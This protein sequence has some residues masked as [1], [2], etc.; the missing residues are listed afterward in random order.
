MQDRLITFRRYGVIERFIC[1]DSSI[2]TGILFFTLILFSAC[3]AAPLVKQACE[4]KDW[5]IGIEKGADPLQVNW[6]NNED[7]P[8][9]GPKEVTDRNARFTADPFLLPWKNTWYLFFEVMNRGT[10]QGDIGYAISSDLVHWQYQK[11]I[12]DEPFHLSYPYV[13]RSHGSFYMIPESRQAKGIRLY[14]AKSFPEKWEFIKELIPGNFSDSSIIYFNNYW[15]LFTCDVPYSLNIFYSK[16]IFG[17]W[18]PH[19]L[20]PITKDDKTKS[21]PGGRMILDK[22]HPIRFAQDGT[23]GYGHSIRA[24]IIDR[25]TSTQYLEHEVDTKPFRSAGGNSWRWAG[26]HTYSPWQLQDGTWAASVDGAGCPP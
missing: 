4:S 25:L 2:K 13:F 9:L 12:L 24:F 3:S 15:W 21:R 22:G 19:R 26:M 11:I 10:E 16:N 5:S 18:K 7:A 23:G 20:N 14:K 1:R 6:I 17:P 8:L